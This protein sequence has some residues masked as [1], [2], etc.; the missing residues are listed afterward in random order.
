MKTT[1]KLL[2]G[3]VTLSLALAMTA[4]SDNDKPSTTISY[5]NTSAT[6]TAVTTTVDENTTSS[7]QTTEE[8]QTPIGTTEDSTSEVTTTTGEPTNTAKPVTTTTPTVTT[9]PTQ[10]V[11]AS[12]TTTTKAPVITSTKKTETQ[13]TVTTSR[14]ATT[15]TKKVTTTTKKVTTTTKKVTTTVTTTKKATTT[16]TYS[17]PKNDA[18]E[19]VSDMKIGWNLGNTFD[20]SDCSWLSNELS[21]ETGWQNTKTT[22]KHIQMLKDAGFN[23]VRIPVS[24]HNHLTDT[25]NYTI[26]QAWLNRVKEV[27]DYCIEQDMY[28]IINTHHDIDKNYIYP[29]NAHLTQSKKYINS[30]WKQIANTFK[31][32]DEH[33]LFESMNE[34]RLVGHNNEWWINASNADCKEAISCINTLNQE[35]VNTVRAT[36]GNNKTRFLLVTGYDS[37]PD[38]AL[39][40]GFV[41][42]TDSVSTNKNRIIVEVHAY[43]PWNFTANSSGSETW[44]SSNASQKREITSFMDK[45]YKTFIKNG[46]A[47]IIDEFGATDGNNLTSRVD[48][49][50]FYVSEAKKRGIT[51]FWWDNNGFA[52]NG[53]YTNG[54]NFGLLD[55]KN[56]TWK[57]TQILDAMMKSFD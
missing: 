52:T 20:A 24:W 13:K 51:C 11:T 23:S 21:Y 15:T 29:D 3:F 12:K 27:V 49:A 30:V 38:G 54:N 35:F 7:A 33:L 16:T 46:T 40:S 26:S 48:W 56:Y 43:T 57:F 45:L 19:L 44:S 8:A 47:V 25:T 18:M 41:L 50:G 39:N 31:N 2:C 36:G 37:S 14:K 5:K 6:T 17:I 9:T 34:P 22:K 42:P 32:Y 28:V 55:R 53:D 1:K 10:T 4:C